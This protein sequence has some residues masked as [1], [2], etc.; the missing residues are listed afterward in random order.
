MDLDVYADGVVPVPLTS[1]TLENSV[2][3]PKRSI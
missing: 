1:A 3:S 2:R